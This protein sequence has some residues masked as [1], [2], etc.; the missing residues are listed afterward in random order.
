MKAEVEKRLARYG[1]TTHGR[2]WVLKAL[3]PVDDVDT[4]GMPD[5]STAPV[6]RPEFRVQGT[7]QPPAGAVSTYD[8]FIYALPGDVNAVYWAT[9][10]S[11]ADFTATTMPAAATFGRLQMQSCQLLESTP[12]TDFSVG[13]PFPQ[14]T[15]YSTAPVSRP[16][17]SRHYYKSL[18]VHLIAPDIC[19]QGT[20]YAAQFPPRFSNVSTVSHTGEYAPFNI[21]P[22]GTIAGFP[23]SI[24]LPLSEEELMLMAPDALTG[25]AKD[26][27]Y[28][29]LHMSGPNQP[30]PDATTPS[31]FAW[32]DGGSFGML[33]YFGPGNGPSSVSTPQA[34][35]CHFPVLVRDQLRPWV[36]LA[37]RPYANLPP[38]SQ[39][40]TGWDSGY[41][42]L[43]AGV[44]IFR[45]IAAGSG[46]AFGASLQVKALVGLEIVPRPLAPDRVFA[47][48]A[49][50]FD[51]KA[52][53]VYYSVLHELHQ[54]YPASY[55]AFGL[56]GPMIMSALARLAP[57]VMP[58]LA[59]AGAEVAKRATTFLMDRARPATTQ[60][61]P[62]RPA[63][64]PKAKPQK[65]PPRKRR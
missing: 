39:P 11:P 63:A 16:L 25:P 46:G 27:V 19:N 32:G 49:A 33:H 52:M 4:E 60:P 58:M 15:C 14:G 2:N 47:R 59:S 23:R 13:P 17:A 45:G 62:A 9:A 41:D 10:P 38:S 6:L 22:N 42:N 54:A 44:V 65:G 31:T 3:N 40:L 64:K 20:V 43:N 18:T 36:S 56:L 8:V 28:M 51:P 24:R 55:N 53:E 48:P 1:L 34:T 29:P 57:I 5:Q 37:A 30:F 12:I 61:T 21:T 35:F 7:I 26:G 50:V